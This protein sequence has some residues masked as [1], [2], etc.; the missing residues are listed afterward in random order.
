MKLPCCCSRLQRAWV[1]G[2]VPRLLGH[3]VDK[4]GHL[5]KELLLQDHHAL[6]VAYQL[7]LAPEAEEP[8]MREVCS[9]SRP[10]VEPE[11]YMSTPSESGLGGVGGRGCALC[12]VD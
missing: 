9:P 5:G 6:R 12:I 3:G 7:A 2:R 11:V 1:D 8:L 10:P 4:A